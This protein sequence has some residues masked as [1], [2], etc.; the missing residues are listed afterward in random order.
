MTSA[1]HQEPQVQYTDTQGPNRTT[2][3]PETIAFIAIGADAALREH[4]KE[5][6]DQHTY[7]DLDSFSGHTGFMQSVIEPS[8]FLDLVWDY[9]FTRTDPSGVFAYDI[10][11]PFGRSVAEKMLDMDSPAIEGECDQI[12]IYHLKEAGYRADMIKPAIQQAR[13]WLRA[14]Q[15]KSH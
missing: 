6:G 5:C 13:A 7:P 9:F 8:L 15:A 11:E 3:C 10:A 14:G 1:I 12:L 2:P 4:A